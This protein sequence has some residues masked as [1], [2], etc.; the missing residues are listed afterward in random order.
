MEFDNNNFFGDVVRAG[1]DFHEYGE[2]CL[3]T[4]F[5]SSDYRVWGGRTRT[6]P[7]LATERN[8]HCFLERGGFPIIVIIVYVSL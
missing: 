8:K 6:K 7:L 1:S 5:I 3:L 4:T 2:S